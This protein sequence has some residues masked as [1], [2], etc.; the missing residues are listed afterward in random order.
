[1]TFV[2][3][4]VA[5]R[6]PYRK[7]FSSMRDATA[8]ITF[9][10]PREKNVY[11]SLYQFRDAES[12]GRFRPVYSSAIVDKIL[13]DFDCYKNNGSGGEFFDFK[14]RVSAIRL[15]DY[16]EKNG[17]KRRYYFTGGGY[18]V[19]VSATGGSQYLGRATYGLVEGAGGISIDPSTVGD[20]S[21]MRRAPNSFNW[22]DAKKKRGAGADYSPGP[23]C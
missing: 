3:T 7:C 9:F 15:D 12:N 19:Y 6:V 10:N 5:D 4:G 16:L 2:E 11:I 17:I 1:M 8:D 21:Q 14:E 18:H 13:F 22:G 20:T 23:V